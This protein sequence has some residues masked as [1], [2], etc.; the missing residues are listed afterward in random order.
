MAAKPAEPLGPR[1]MKAVSPAAL[2]GAVQ[3][4][5]VA[6]QKLMAAEA[7]GDPAQL[8][9]ARASFYVTL[10]GMADALTLAQL[11][12]APAELDPQIQGA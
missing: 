11:G 10:F 6:G 4:T 1:G 3:S 5:F 8:R 7:A 12:A 9:K 2:G